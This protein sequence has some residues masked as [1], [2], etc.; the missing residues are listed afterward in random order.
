MKS[1]GNQG[2]IFQLC[3]RLS[4]RRRL[5]F[6]SFLKSSDKT[7]VEFAADKFRV[8]N[9]LAKEWQRRFNSADVVFIEG[10]SQA[11]D[12]FSAV[13]SLGSKFRDHRV[14]VN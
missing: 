6:A 12:C 8:A 10:P 3:L 2:H 14:V 13:A 4:V 5:A 11:I 7:G 9:D 1:R